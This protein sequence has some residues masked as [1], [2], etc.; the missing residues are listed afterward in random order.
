MEYLRELQSQEVAE[1][2][3]K[4]LEIIQL[5]EEKNAIKKERPIG[6]PSAFGYVGKP[7]KRFFTHC[8]NIASEFLLKSI[9]LFLAKKEPRYENETTNTLP[10]WFVSAFETWWGKKENTL[11]KRRTGGG[12]ASRNPTLIINYGHREITLMIPAQHIQSKR[13]LDEVVFVVQSSSEIIYEST[14]PLYHEDDDYVSEEILLPISVP[15][16]TYHVEMISVDSSKRFPPIEVFSEQKKYACFDYET[17]RLMSNSPDTLDRSACVVFSD[18][19]A[20]QPDSAI[21][22]SGRFYGSWYGYSYYFVDPQYSDRGIVTI[23]SAA[24]ISENVSQRYPSVTLENYQSLDKIRINNKTVISGSPPGLVLSLPSLEELSGYRLSIHPLSP[25]TISETRVYSYN[26][27]KDH[28]VL[29]ETDSVCR[30]NLAD[31][32]FF[33]EKPVGTFAVR[34]RNEQKNLDQIFEFSIIPELSV[35]FSKP[36]YLPGNDNSSVL[37]MM[38]SA[39]LVNCSAEEPVI[40]KRKNDSWILFGPVVQ[41]IT[42]TLKVHIPGKE[43]F[44]GIFSV[45]VPHLSWR[46]ENPEKERIGPIHRTKVTVSDDKYDELGDGK[47]VTIFMPEEYNGI[48]TITLKPS[49]TYIIKNIQNGKALFPLSRF[50]DALRE[51]QDNKISFCF[52]FESQKERF[53]IPLFTLKKWRISAFECPVTTEDENRTMTFSWQELGDVQKRSLIIWKA[54]LG[55]SQPQKNTEIS[56][57]DDAKSLSISKARNLI[58]PG[59]YYAQFIRIQDEWSSTPVLFPGEQT[60]NFFQFSV[61]LERSELLNEGDELLSSGQYIAAIERYKE[62]EHLN[63][64]L[65]SLWKQKIHNTFMYTY[66]YDEVLKL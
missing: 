11:H 62:L 54:G 22:E 35:S 42:G 21:I 27:F 6:R 53:E 34:L 28:C 47:T 64:Q 48:G 24:E 17:G 45:P 18:P 40:V 4:H 16:D 19:I 31:E 32:V 2:E 14:H 26:E 23:G 60:P 29:D 61:E 36:L 20:I 65:G 1:I 25:G 55:E 41:N 38:T 52:S 46:F 51:I 49:D 12:T 66:R 44:S 9:N 57:P 8:D 7:I 3:K 58:P 59:V 39:E 56:I 13:P 37:L 15:S 33:G 63:S 43:P 5:I 10:E 50:N 30:F